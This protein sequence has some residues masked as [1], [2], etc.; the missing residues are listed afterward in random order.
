M[1]RAPLRINTLFARARYALEQTP[2]ASPPGDAAKP[3]GDDKP[4][5]PDADRQAAIDAAVA[6]AL[7]T[8]RKAAADKAAKDKSDAEAADA[9]K[10]GEFEKVANTEKAKR[11]EAEHKLALRERDIAV[12]DAL[13]AHADY[14]TC[15]KY[16][17]PL[18]DAT[19]QGDA[20]AKAAKAAVEDYIKDN[21]RTP[22]GSVG[23]PPAPRGSRIPPTRQPNQ[24]PS[25]AG[26]A[27]SRF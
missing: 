4:A 12:R 10:R 8:E 25:T 17:T 3:K 16:V 15:A 26:V 1:G 11:E 7:A 5:N 21:P 22:K 13:A 2:P 6:S 14:A 24:R 19:F 9:I 27:S 18:V 23:A 20:L